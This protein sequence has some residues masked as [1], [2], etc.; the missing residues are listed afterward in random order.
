MATKYKLQKD[1]RFQTKVWKGAYDKHGRKKYEPIYSDK[2]SGDLEKKVKA[3]KEGLKEGRYTLESDKL[4]T[5]YA[6]EWRKI[7]KATASTNTKA[8]YDNIINKHFSFLDGFKL[9]DLHRIHYQQLLN[10]AAGKPRTRQQID[11][12]FRQVIKSAI[13]DKLLPKNYY[14]EIFSELK[15]P[16]YKPSEKRPL[17]EVEKKAILKANFTPREQAFVLII[18]ACGLRRGEALALTP[19]SINL[20]KSEL[21]VNKSIEF[22]GNNPERKDTK[23][24][25]VRTIPMPQYLSSFLETYIPTIKGDTLISKQ[26]GALMTKSSYDKMWASITRKMNDAAGGS[27]KVTIIHNLTAHIFRHNFCTALCYQIPLISIDQIA[28]LLGDTKKMV[29]EVYSH[30]MREKENPAQVITQAMTL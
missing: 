19:T 20:E 11:M 8:M 3:I 27:N 12:V 5:D 29:V 18:Y 21:T 4:F 26:D 2:S 22:D 9:Q 6:E 28:Y 10:N 13:R 7:Y 24:E 30:V 23:N 25:K 17:T 14:D 16:K 1:G 15:R